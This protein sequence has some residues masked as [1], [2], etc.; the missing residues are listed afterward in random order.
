MSLV[1]STEDKQQPNS[2]LFTYLEAY[3]NNFKPLV[4]SLLV[5]QY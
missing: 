3:T 1:M 2:K 5:L 4:P